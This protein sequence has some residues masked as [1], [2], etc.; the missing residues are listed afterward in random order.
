MPHRRTIARRTGAALA[1]AAALALTIGAL[2]AA[3]PL[4]D[5]VNLLRPVLAAIG[6]AGAGLL[7]WA[8]A[9]R[10]AAAAAV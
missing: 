3:V 10:A 2:G 8:R 4:F 9:R 5:I 6:V 7:L 1:L